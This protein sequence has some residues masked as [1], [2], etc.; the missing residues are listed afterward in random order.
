[1]FCFTV[2]GQPV[3]AEREQPL[4]DFLRDTLRL[5]SVKEGCGEGA[6]GT[7]TVLVDGKKQ[8]ACL[9]TTRKA[10]RPPL[11]VAPATSAAA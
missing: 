11:M 1:M 4:L 6:C 7:C 8:R 2:N 10:G 9:L 3:Q 5:T